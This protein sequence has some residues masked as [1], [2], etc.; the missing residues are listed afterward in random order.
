MKLLGAG[1]FL[2]ATGVVCTIIYVL[3]TLYGLSATGNR[4][5]L[6]LYAGIVLIVIGIVV[7]LSGHAPEVQ[8]LCTHFSGRY[9]S[10]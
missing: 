9:P 8:G 2:I 7:R 4:I 6:L 5:T 3:L 10:K 1:R